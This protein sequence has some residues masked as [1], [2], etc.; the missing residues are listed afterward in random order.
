MSRARAAMPALAEVGGGGLSVVDVVGDDAPAVPPVPA[1][2]LDVEHA[3]ALTDRIRLTASTIRERWERLVQL[4][5]QAKDGGVAQTLGYAS[6]TAYLA[7]VLGG[8]LRLAGPERQEWVAYLT[9]QGMSTRAIAPIVGASPKTVARDVAASRPEPVSGDTP[10]PVVVGRDGKAYPRPRLTVVEP[11]TAQQG[12]VL[13]VQPSLALD[14]LDAAPEGFP[15]MPEVATFLEPVIGR[16]EQVY[17]QAE[18]HGPVAALEAVRAKA[19]ESCAY[20]LRTWLRTE[21]RPDLER[22]TLWAEIDA[23]CDRAAQRTGSPR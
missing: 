20:W 10:A 7:D 17:R 1:G 11:P 21:A 16:A 23:R 5:E 13:D 14:S 3:R 22:A 2:I 4:V 19:G 6:W 18:L 9:G 12:S 15:A 8:Q